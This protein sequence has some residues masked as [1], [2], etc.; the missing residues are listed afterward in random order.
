MLCSII[1]DPY[2]RVEVAQSAHA[3]TKKQTTTKRK[4]SHPVFDETFTFSVSPRMDDL[5]Y[6]SLNIMV[7]DHDRI[8][9]DDV[10]GR[11]VLGNGSTEASE[12][13]HWSEILANPGHLVTKWHYLVELDD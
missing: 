10:I 5:T 1:S 12:F 9:S 13:D 3:P 8:R 2:V 6:T 7:F 11:V 4:T